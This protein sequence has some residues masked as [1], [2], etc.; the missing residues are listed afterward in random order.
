MEEL[1]I[2]RESCKSCRYCVHN[3]PKGALSVS[4]RI[5]SK[6]YLPVQVDSGKCIQC[7]VCYTVCPDYVFEIREREVI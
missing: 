2:H 7:G 3:C 4:D 6:G 1:I 5:N